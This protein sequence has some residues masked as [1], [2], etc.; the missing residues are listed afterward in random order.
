M[1]AS[2]GHGCPLWYVTDYCPDNLAP[3]T[4]D[5]NCGHSHIMVPRLLTLNWADFKIH[6][7]LHSQ[8]LTRP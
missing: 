5:V 7:T 2:V 1:S 3:L 6:P 4:F 8:T